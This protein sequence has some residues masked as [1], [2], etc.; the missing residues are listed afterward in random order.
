MK[1]LTEC[2][3]AGEAIAGTMGEDD[4]TI[5]SKMHETVS[6]FAFVKAVAQIGP[7]EPIPE[8][9]YIALV[10][11]FLAICSNVEVVILPEQWVGKWKATSPLME[12][13][14]GSV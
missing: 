2:H 6:N 7:K 1:Q 10:Q 14:A 13:R 12:L 3:Q 4:E 11:E 8:A 9:L 5:L